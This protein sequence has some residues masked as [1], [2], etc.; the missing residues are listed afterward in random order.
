MDAGPSFIN[1]LYPSATDGEGTTGL[2]DY[3]EGPFTLSGAHH[4][5]RVINQSINQTKEPLDMRL[6]RNIDSVQRRAETK[7]GQ[8]VDRESLPRCLACN[9]Q[10]SVIYCD[11]AP[12]CWT[13]LQGSERDSS[14]SRQLID[15]T[16]DDTAGLAENEF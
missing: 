14:V 15:L 4:S 6:N 12:Y 13:S 1:P 5:F 3:D 16:D 7:S 11:I 10:D 9:L 8:Y 2:E